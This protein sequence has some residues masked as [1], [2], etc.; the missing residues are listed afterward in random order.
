[1]FQ[2]THIRKAIPV[3]L[4]AAL[5]GILWWLV[6]RLPVADVRD[7]GKASLPTLPIISELSPDE[8]PLLR[9]TT[10][11][12]QDI[13][14]ETVPGKRL[15]RIIDAD[16]APVAGAEVGFDLPTNVVCASLMTCAEPVL[17]QYPL[18]SDV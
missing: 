14:S 6:A 18:S 5:G 13:L 7:D 11:E 17:V 12:D 2:R 16:G 9:S 4:L 15:V 8:A 3:V 1:M 10:N